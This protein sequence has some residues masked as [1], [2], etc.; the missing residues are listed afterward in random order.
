MTLARWIGLIALLT[1]VFILWQIRQVLLLLFAAVVLATAINTLAMWP[2]KWGLPR[3]PALLVTLAGLVIVALGL[4][5]L[6]FPPFASQLAE[7][8]M[9]LPSGLARLEG[10]I[11]RMETQ[12]PFLSRDT[13]DIQNFLQ[14]AQPI[15]TRVLGGGFTVFSTTLGVL[16]NVLL[17]LVL[18]LM[19]LANPRSY[20]QAFISL[21]PSFYRR[22]IDTILDRC[23]HA[24]QGWLKGILFNMFV[25]TSLSLIGLLFLG[26]RLPLA[27]A[28]LAGLLTFIPNIGPTLSVIPPA[29]VALLDEP[30]KAGA[31]VGL[32]VLIQQIESNLLTPVVMAQQVELLPAV[33]LLAQVVCAVFFGFGGL[34]LAL[35]ITVVS[36]VWL[37]EVLVRDVLDKWQKGDDR[38]VVELTNSSTEAD[39]LADKPDGK[40]K[41]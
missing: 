1:S 40:Q 10:L 11:E 14:G 13:L 9:L 12:I 18:A 31:V 37:Q 6:A 33:T 16:L 35:P 26:V 24:L 15:V 22:R 21:F 39:D 5:N 3:F 25:I 17:V 7:L 4:G 20:R 29:V 19:L 23:Q 28:I 41:D 27:N 36:Q 34:L 38:P 8:Q 2:Q 30:W 32:Y